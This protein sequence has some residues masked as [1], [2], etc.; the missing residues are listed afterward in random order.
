MALAGLGIGIAMATTTSAAL[1]EISEER[2]GVGSAVLQAL[3]KVGGPFGTAILGSVLSAG[4][5]A[6]VDATGLPA[7]A[8]TTVRQSV[9]SGVAVAHQVGSAALLESVRTAFVQGMD[10][11]L[12][13]SAGIAVAGIVLTLRYLPRTSAPEV[14]ERASVGK[15]AEVGRTR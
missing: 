14:I 13:V 11:A 1:V 12:L 9:F 3:N 6:H 8:A 4:Y 10:S 15:E 2:S 7:A 5:L